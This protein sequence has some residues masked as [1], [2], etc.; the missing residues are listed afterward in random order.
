M[1]RDEVDWKE[2]KTYAYGTMGASA[3]FISRHEKYPTTTVNQKN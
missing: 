3:R 1:R 2:E